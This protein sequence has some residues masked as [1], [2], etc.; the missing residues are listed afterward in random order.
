MTQ[1]EVDLIYDYLHE[2]CDYKDGELIRKISSCGQSIGKKIGSLVCSEKNRN[3]ENKPASIRARIKIDGKVYNKKLA[4]LVY[5][6]HY[7]S[8]PTNLQRLDGNPLNTNIKNLAVR[9]KKEL[10]KTRI[11][12]PSSNRSNMGITFIKEKNKFRASTGLGGK[13]LLIGYFVNEDEAIKAVQTIRELYFNNNLSYEELRKIIEN[14]YRVKS[15]TGYK[16][17]IKS[18][19]GYRFGYSF[20]VNGTLHR[21]LCFKTIDE[22]YDAYLKAKKELISS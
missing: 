16:N 22:A 21:K 2:H 12:N 9:D 4:V 8:Y 14:K 15:K 17:I 13:R 19:S 6:F 7:K 20:M 18:R 3:G 1:D 10:Y 5:I 11:L